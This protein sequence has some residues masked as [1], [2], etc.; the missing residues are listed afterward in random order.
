MFYARD[1]ETGTLCEI[2]PD[3]CVT[4]C[5]SCGK[6]MTVDIAELILSGSDL[7]GT[8]LF[9]SKE[10][11]AKRL[12]SPQDKGCDGCR[13]EVLQAVEAMLADEVAQ[14]LAERCCDEACRRDVIKQR[15]RCEN[16][17]L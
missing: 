17:K 15:M 4:F 5:G 14:F 16:G 10:C 8:T 12:E 7:I 2:W 11:T 13:E 1:E 3:E 6:E 9:C